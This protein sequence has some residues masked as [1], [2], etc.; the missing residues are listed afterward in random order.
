MERETDDSSM[1]NSILND[2]INQIKAQ[3]RDWSKKIQSKTASL[4]QL[5]GKLTQDFP[6]NDGIEKI[7]KKI[8]KNLKTSEKIYDWGKTV[9]LAQQIK[10]NSTKGGDTLKSRDTLKGGEISNIRTHRLEISNLILQ[11]LESELVAEKEENVRLVQLAE[12]KF[13]KLK[14]SKLVSEKDFEKCLNSNVLNQ[15]VFNN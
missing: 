10:Q 1:T 13:K 4:P 5:K 15:I 2:T 8:E 9:E 14:Q 12:Q 3:S 11:K 7:E 6:S